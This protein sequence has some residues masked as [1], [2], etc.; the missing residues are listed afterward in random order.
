MI[1]I[2]KKLLEENKDLASRLQ[3]VLK[4]TDDARDRQRR[5]HLLLEVN[6][7]IRVIRELIE[8]AQRIQARQ[9]KILLE[10]SKDNPQ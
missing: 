3:E 1:E 2:Q 6:E 8:Q 7:Q 10:L 5:E 9:K 4:R